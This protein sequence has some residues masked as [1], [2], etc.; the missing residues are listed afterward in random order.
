[1]LSSPFHIGASDTCG[2]LSSSPYFFALISSQSF[3]ARAAGFFEK[4][5][6]SHHRIR[7]RRIRI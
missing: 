5:G 6:Q 1:M 7:I 4:E 3:I 2:Y